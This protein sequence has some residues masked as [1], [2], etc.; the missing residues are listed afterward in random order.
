M[1]QDEISR[2]VWLAS[3]PKSGNTW[4]R[5]L[6]R[7]LETG[8]RPSLNQL[9]AG[10]GGPG[11]ARS[12][13]GLSPSDLSPAELA[14]V[15]RR[16]WQHNSLSHQGVAVHKTHDAFGEAADGY[17]LHGQPA[18]VRAV[19]LVRDP[20]AVAVSWAH[21]M[22]SSL[23]HAVDLMAGRS[24]VH[25]KPGSLEEASDQPSWSA[26]VESWLEQT[27]VP[28]L[29][30]RYEDLSADPESWTSRI[31]SWVGLDVSTE[32]VAEAVRA[33]RFVTLAAAELVEGFSERVT[34]DRP[35][36]RRGE[37][38]AWRHELPDA[39]AERVLAEHHPVMV[40]LGYA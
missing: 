8:S 29:V 14:P 5:A 30:V 27:Q 34:P 17:P 1:T 40:R 25:S 2:V 16:A 33:T 24:A 19:Y 10:G 31:A 28:V 9:G 4:V 22:G 15:L 23:A 21:H 7:V 26:H 39:L 35:F 18:G 20:R 12:V 37:P 13:L 11:I 3:F 6:L 36:F 32:R 38:D